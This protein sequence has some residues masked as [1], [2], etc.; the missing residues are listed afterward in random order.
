MKAHTDIH[1]G[2][3]STP[4]ERISFF[5]AGLIGGYFLPTI[6]FGLLVLV[7]RVAG[8]NVAEWTKVMVLISYL[9]YMPTIWFS[10]RKRPLAIGILVV[11]LIQLLVLASGLVLWGVV[12]GGGTLSK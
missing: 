6:V 3:T 7:A 12:R 10:R 9:L 8:V 4:I 5:V 11:A 2:S 1:I